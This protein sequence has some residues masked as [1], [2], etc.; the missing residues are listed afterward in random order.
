MISLVFLLEEPSA[1]ELLKVI[2]S[3]LTPDSIDKQYIVFQGKSDLDRKL[4]R[5][6]CDYQ[7]PK[8][9]FLIL[10]DKD[11]GD[12]EEI[13]ASLINSIPAS[14]R[15][16]SLVRIA[17]HELENFYLGD[18]QAVEKGL[19][20]EGIARQQRKAKYRDPDRLANAKQELKN[21]TKG[22][23]QQI[24]GSRK[25]APHLDLEGSNLSHSFKMLIAGIKKIIEQCTSNID[26]Q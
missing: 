10:R 2:T 19:E 15:K 25:I 17:C 14:K 4:K 20:M 5:K 1:K 6:I 16:V 26:Q 8:A 18:L 21:L 22:H 9:C 23:Y 11:H 12:C 7:V 13:K 24:S 3:K